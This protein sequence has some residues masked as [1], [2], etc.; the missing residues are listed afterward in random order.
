MSSPFGPQGSSPSGSGF[1]LGPS[2]GGSSFRLGS[3]AVD[4]L[5]S[6]LTELSSACPRTGRRI[7]WGSPFPPSFDPADVWGLT[8]RQQAEKLEHFRLNLEQ[9]GI[10]E[11]GMIGS[12][13][14]PDIHMLLRFLKARKYDIDPATEMYVNH[15]T[16]RNSFGVDTTLKDFEYEEKGKFIEFYPQGYH[17]TDKQ[18]RPIYIQQ[19]GKIQMKELKKFTTEERMVKFHVQEYERLV[20]GIMP[21]CSKL[22]N[23]NIDQTFTIMDVKG[24]GLSSFGP[25]VR[26]LLGKIIAIDSD[27][28]PEMMGHMCIINAPLAF[29]AI[30]KLVKPMLDARTQGKIEVCPSDFIPALTKWIDIENIPTFLGGKSEGSLLDDCGA[31]NDPEILRE[32]EDEVKE[33]EGDLEGP[34]LEAKASHNGSVRLASLKEIDMEFLSPRSQSECDSFFSVNNF[35]M[36]DSLSVS[37]AGNPDVPSSAHTVASMSSAARTP[38]QGSPTLSFSGAAH[39]ANIIDRTAKLESQV[40]KAAQRLQPFMPRNYQHVASKAPE[41]S[42][43]HRVETLEDAMTMLL[44]AQEQEYV[45]KGRS[46]QAKRNSC[47]GGC[48]VM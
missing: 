32:L 5:S 40:G 39:N 6:L 8:P 26:A 1:A 3:G 13:G 44:L 38:A 17:K 25:D 28:Y 43:L 10:V 33:I 19:V 46:I 45:Q 16:F 34:G 18:G 42:L 2:P 47:C 7:Y 31:W 4:R 23:K 29:R 30:W 12:P 41:G 21:L 9:R 20:H 27:N 48:C 11:P 35:D 15:I 36:D 14:H 22:H 37:S 24:V